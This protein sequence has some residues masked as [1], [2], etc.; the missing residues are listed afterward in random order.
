MN[1]FPPLAKRHHLVNKTIFFEQ[2]RVTGHLPLGPDNFNIHLLLPS[3][4]QGLPAQG[5]LNG[6]SNINPKERMRTG[7]LH[8]EIHWNFKFGVDQVPGQSIQELCF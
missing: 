6:K 2:L 1:E 4:Q 8:K 7:P 3:L 5:G